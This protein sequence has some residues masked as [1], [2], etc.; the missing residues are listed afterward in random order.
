MTPKIIICTNKQSGETIEIYDTLIQ[1]LF[2]MY[3]VVSF[4]KDRTIIE[5]KALKMKYEIPKKSNVWKFLKKST[6]N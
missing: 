4:D 1:G 5:L 6:T 2:D 3:F